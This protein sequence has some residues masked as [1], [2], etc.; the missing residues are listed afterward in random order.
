MTDLPLNCIS[1]NL[2]I[3]SQRSSNFSFPQCKND[4]S[5]PPNIPTARSEE[6]IR[7]TFLS[8]DNLRSLPSK[9]FKPLSLCMG[10]KVTM[11]VLSLF[12]AS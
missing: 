6:T 7:R 1:A 10:V 2:N 12:Y 9:E 5:W 11:S 4:P 8:Q 3:P